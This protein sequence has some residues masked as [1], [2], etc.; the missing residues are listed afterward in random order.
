MTGLK[1]SM[2]FSCDPGG[3]SG[4]L[5]SSCRWMQTSTMGDDQEETTAARVAAQR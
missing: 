4:S 3:M 2:R 1:V 5:Q